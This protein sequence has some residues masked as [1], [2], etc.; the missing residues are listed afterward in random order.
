MSNFENKRNPAE[1]ALEVLKGLNKF[2]TPEGNVYAEVLGRGDMEMRSSAFKGWLKTKVYEQKGLIANNFQLSDA[3]DI[4]VAASIETKPVFLRTAGSLEAGIYIDNVGPLKAIVHVTRE[5]WQYVPSCPYKFLRPATQLSLP[6]PSKQGSLR[7]FFEF[8]FSCSDADKRLIASWLLGALCPFEHFPFPIL[9]LEGPTGSGKTTLAR[10]CKR[11]V[12]NGSLRPHAMPGNEFDLSSLAQADKTVFIDNASTVSA[13]ISNCLCRM[14]TGGTT[15]RGR[16]YTDT[17]LVHL[18]IHNPVILTGVANVLKKTDAMNRALRV[19]INSISPTARLDEN[20]L[21]S[22][23]EGAQGEILGGLLSALSEAL[24]NWHNTRLDNSP[25]MADF[26]RLACSAASALGTS[27][28][29]LE[30][31]FAVGQEVQQVE[32]AEASFPMQKL[33]TV[34]AETGQVSWTSSE[35]Y[36]ALWPEIQPYSIHRNNLRTK[37]VE[38]AGAL[39]AIGIEFVSQGRT[40]SSRSFLLRLTPNT[41]TKPV[42]MVTMPSK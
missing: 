38:A 6:A 1:S 29:Q 31:A 37:L 42:T 33:K 30:K 24:A 4:A 35:L 20:T 13:E 17:D 19:D 3:I 18:P 21:W 16:K 36:D 22:M 41:V 39:Q 25:R 26:A 12:D 9:L 5:G 27:S 7:R 23:F 11:L 2:Q 32:A 10:V 34:L 28:I 40:G 8:P 14:S 15:S